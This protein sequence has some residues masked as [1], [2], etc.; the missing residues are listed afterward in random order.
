MK[1]LIVLTY[2]GLVI[3]LMQ[4]WLIFAAICLTFI[5]VKS[6]TV[7]ILPVAIIM[8]GYLGGY[9]FIPWLS[10][11]A[12]IWFLFIERLKPRMSSF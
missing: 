9:Y 5:S 7:F 8:D 4:S 1:F 12:L 3:A 2:L 10:I 11:S 6:N